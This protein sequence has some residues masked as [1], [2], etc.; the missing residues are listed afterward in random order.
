MK[1]I[2]IKNEK[3]Y[4]GRKSFFGVE[5]QTINSLG[6]GFNLMQRE[7]GSLNVMLGRQRKHNYY[8]TISYRYL[9][10]IYYYLYRASFPVYPFIKY[11]MQISLLILYCYLFLSSSDEVFFLI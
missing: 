5:V 6:S 10:F 11:N 8:S 4:L 3:A 9:I 7:E 2:N 1:N